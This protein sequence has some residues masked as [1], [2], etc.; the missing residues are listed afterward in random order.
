MGKDND[1]W[2]Q[3]PWIQF[4]ALAFISYLHVSNYVTSQYFWLI[5]K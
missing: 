3:T 2:S 1:F 4:L 5:T